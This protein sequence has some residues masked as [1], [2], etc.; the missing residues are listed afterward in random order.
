MG[1][2]EQVKYKEAARFAAA[3]AA[4][5]AAAGAGAATG[6]EADRLYRQMVAEPGGGVWDCR[7]WV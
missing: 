2:C 4:A 1:P 6:A 7:L 5:A 3:A